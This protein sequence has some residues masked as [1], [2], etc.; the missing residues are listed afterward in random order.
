MK[1]S[2]L[3]FLSVLGWPHF[4]VKSQPV[5]QTWENTDIRMIATN[6]FLTG[7][8]KIEMNCPARATVHLLFVVI[9]PLWQFHRRRVSQ[10]L[11]SSNVNSVEK[12]MSSVVSR[13]LLCF[14]MMKKENK[15]IRFWGKSWMRWL[16]GHCR[17]YIWGSSA[18]NLY[19]TSLIFT[20]S[21]RLW[22]YLEQ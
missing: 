21:G 2:V 18:W 4:L 8:T 22:L 20:R 16:I 10:I 19:Q 12:Q 9:V 7:Q 1:Y 17:T 6:F 14:T 11:R 5:F 13:L 3:S 15:G